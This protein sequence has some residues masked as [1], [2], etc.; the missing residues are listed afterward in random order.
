MKKILFV[1]RDGTLIQEPADQQIDSLEKLELMDH[2][3]GSLLSLI[4]HGYRL[5]MIT[6]QDGLGSPEYPQAQ[7]DLVQTKLLSLLGSQGI[8]FDDILI[9][10]HHPD[11][12]C[13]C[14]KPHLALL[15]PYLKDPQIDWHHSYVIGDRLSDMELARRMG[16]Q[17][18]RVGPSD[19]SGCY[20]WQ[21]LTQLIITKPRRAKVERCT[22]ETTVAVE[23]RLDETQPTKVQTSYGFFNH[24]LEQISC[25]GGMGLIITAAG[26]EHID[27]HHLI[28]DTA[29][30]LGQALRQALGDKVNLTR[31]GFALPMDEARCEVLI[32][33][34]ER[35]FFVFNGTALL[36]HA[37]V[38]DIDVDMIVHFFRSLAMSL[39]CN[40]HMKVSGDNAHHMVEALFKALGQ[41]LKKACA[42][43][44]APAGHVPSTK[45][46]L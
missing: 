9:C 37:V 44:G 2:V 36:R 31:Y 35:P 5:V 34:S 18:Y 40:L 28:E 15:A 4:A 42:R 20:H 25:H 19:A 22:K 3:I 30:T 17:G 33:L 38:G 46:S 11:E 45:G 7:F 32:D 41:C 23:V 21:E 6:N 10:P 16:V 1:D 8:H 12:H 24:M 43:G 13:G 27:S 26:D 14:R 39:K 29:I